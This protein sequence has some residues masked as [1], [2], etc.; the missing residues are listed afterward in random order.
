MNVFIRIAFVIILF[1]GFINNVSSQD[2]KIGDISDGN[3]S[4]PVHLIPLIDED[5]SVVRI[6]DQP[7]LPFSTKNTCGK[8]H[9]YNKV[10]TGWHF[11]AGDSGNSAGRPGHPWIIAD[12]GSATQIPVSLHDWPG[13]LKPEE[14][15]INALEYLQLFG[16]HMPGGSVGDNESLRSLDNAFRW[17]VSGNMEINCLSCHDA[18]FSHDQA[19]QAANTAKQNLRW[20]SAAS[21]GFANVYGSARDMPD[22]YDIYWGS[23]PDVAKKTPPHVIYD[24]T[25]FN[26]KNE[27]YF[28]LDRKVP[29]RNCY[30]CH[31]SKT[32]RSDKQE[33]WMS[34]VDVH[35]KAGMKC[36]DCHRNGLN[37]DMVRG[38]EGELLDRSDPTAKIKDE[39][40]CAGCHLESGR[41]GAPKPVHAG[42]PPVHFEKLSCTTCHSGVLSQGEAPLIKTSQ[43]HGLGVHGI[44]KSDS[45]LPHI[46]SNIM[47]RNDDEKIRPHN[48]IW[49]SYWGMQDSSGITP[50]SV[51]HIRDY[52]SP[53]I[54][55]DDTLGKGDWLAL[56][57]TQKIRILDTLKK[58]STE[59]QKPV[60]V[61]GGKITYLRNDSTLE[62]D[63]HKAAA[64]YYWAFGHDV[65]PAT[66]S[67]GVN[68]CTDCHS[69]NSDFYYSNVNI[70][71]PIGLSKVV[72]LENIDFLDLNRTGAWVFSMSF[73]FRP[74]LKIFIIFCTAILLTVLLIYVVKV[75]LFVT[76]NLGK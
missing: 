54:V 64:P 22:N 74:W 14:V 28:D 7:M 9:D 71:S 47:I 26:Q 50:V 41:L 12:Q 35:L 23:A 67:L 46:L 44:N 57:D 17:R 52:T 59:Y 20:I 61:A 13:A 66:Q 27:I 70:D 29:D 5:S 42:L 75:V 3:R 51:K 69:G 30:F 36:V 34:E 33:R 48:M 56:S 15:G 65:R 19:A 68:G 45:T 63:S 73:L 38:Y 24:L 55:N 49:P 8:C 6:G 72:S 76:E 40:S 21:S 1:A 2:Q 53:F 4:I 58:I 11:T 18:E 25:R 39:F 62:Q 16:R 10:R 60:F 31:S 37:H 43:G 32:L